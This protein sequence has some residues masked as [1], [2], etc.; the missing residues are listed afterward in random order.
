LN[1]RAKYFIAGASSSIIWGFFSISLRSIKDHPSLQILVFRI[2]TSLVI[3]ILI[4]LLIR[5]RIF[6]RDVQYLES[7]VK[8]E[9][10][11]LLLRI[12]YS[13]LFVTANWFAFIYVINHVSVQAGAFAYMVCPI[14]TAV[15]AYLFLKEKL[16]TIK[17]ISIGL[18]F[19]SIAFLS[20]GFITEVIYS[21][22]IAVLYAAYLMLQKRIEG[23]DKL[24]V[25]MVQLLISSVLIIPFIGFG[26]I[27]F[28]TDLHFWTQIV[29]ISVCFT[30]IPLFLSLYALIGMPSSTMGIL[31]YIN[32]IVSF[33]VAFF[34]FDESSTLQKMIAY[35][36]L[37]I[38]VI[39]FNYS[40]IKG[41]FRIQIN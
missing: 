7:L 38:S 18:C 9:R 40:F 13:S 27:E 41:M 19:L 14:I 10:N 35:F 3:T 36:I 34:Y 8:K 22:I 32:P 39:L 30:I 4:S 17:W 16:S 31:I 2:L 23:L 15:F 24:N 26:N 29:I 28:T 5:R 20:L 33:L 1:S 11:Q 12:L 25:L 21:V 6:K 37:L